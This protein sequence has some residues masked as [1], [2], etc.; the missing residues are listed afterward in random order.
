LRL[1]ESPKQIEG[2]N[3][4][5]HLHIKILNSF[6]NTLTDMP[7]IMSKNTP[8]HPCPGQLDTNYTGAAAPGISLR[9]NGLL[10]KKYL[11]DKAYVSNFSNPNALYT[12]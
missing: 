1:D 6:R 11:F 10:H 8:G 4:L 7:R 9:N 5:I 3:S 2:I 12:S